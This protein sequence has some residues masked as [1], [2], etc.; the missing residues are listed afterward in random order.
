LSS[1]QIPADL[2]PVLD[3][4][5][6]RIRKPLYLRMAEWVKSHPI[7]ALLLTAV[8]GVVLNLI[9]SIIYENAKHA[10]PWLG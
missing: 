2:I 3:R 8:S 6:S 4:K 7:I 10:W 9:A 5:L 1:K